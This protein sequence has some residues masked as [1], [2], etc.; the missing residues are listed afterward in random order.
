[1]QT[2]VQVTCSKGRSLRDAIVKDPRLGDYNLAVRRTRKPGRSHGWAELHSVDPNRRGALKI[3]WNPAASVL[4]C[5]VVN[6][7]GGTPEGL[8]GDFV[9]YLFGRHTKRIWALNVVP[10]R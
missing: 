10:D 6:R 5:R 1:M 3:Q 2:L 7:R 9:G 8:L 4:F